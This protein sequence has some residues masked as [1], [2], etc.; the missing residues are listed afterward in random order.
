M[1]RSRTIVS[2]LQIYDFFFIYKFFFVFLILFVFFLFGYQL[3]LVDN[4][5]F[6][7]M[8]DGLDVWLVFGCV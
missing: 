8:P 5:P 1:M 6:L 3:F 2:N 7:G 4:F